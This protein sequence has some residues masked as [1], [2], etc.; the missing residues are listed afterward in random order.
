MAKKLEQLKVRLRRERDG[1]YPIVIGSGIFPA[2]ARE[3]KRQPLGSGY[4]IISD[5]TV[6]R[7][8]G[9]RLLSALR[10]HKLKA[11]LLTFPAGEKSK[12]PKVW[13]ALIGRMLE[14]GLGRDA[15]VIAL[16]G[17]VTGDLAGFAAASYLRGVP[18]IQVPTS[19]LAMVDA[20]IGGKVGL[21]L[22]QGKNLVGAFWQPK[23]VYVDLDC[24]KTLPPLH[25]Q[26][27]LAEVVKSAMIAD[28]ELYEL[29]DNHTDIV[30]APDPR[31][32]LQMIK[33]SLR[34]KATVV[35]KD[36]LETLGLRK[37]LNYGHTIG[38]ALEA[39]SNYRLLHGFAIALGMQA[40]ARIAMDMG[41]LHMGDYDRQNLL[42]CT[43]GFPLQMPARLSA[44]LKTREGKAQ[45]FAYL[46][47]DKKVKA[48]RVEMVLLRGIGR[49]K[50]FEDNWTVPVSAEMIE[51]GLQQIS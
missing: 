28:A 24:L 40:A 38:H 7:L 5:A 37:I 22:A 43:L 8:H 32:L 48:G 47:K 10:A 45:F 19:L 36:E 51:A 6:A 14:A 18:F 25:L 39:L 30:E 27:G 49:V 26:N 46:F 9:P 15:A 13:L 1:S 35:E 12:N 41:F 20:S 2:L 34:V 29:L 31:I 16:G 33:R 42:L 11:R 4:A 44:R 3:L 17:G 50:K 21:D 23:A